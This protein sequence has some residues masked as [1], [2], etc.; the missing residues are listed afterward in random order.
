[1]PNSNILSIFER[2]LAFAFIMKII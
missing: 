1:M 2:K